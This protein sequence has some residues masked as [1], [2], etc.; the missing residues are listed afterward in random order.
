MDFWGTVVV[1]FRRWYIT[2]PAFF[3]TLVAA[4]A[5]LTAVPLQYESG[6]VLALTTPLSG[7]T[8]TDNP[9]APTSLTNPLLGFDQSLALTAS[10]VIQQLNSSETAR[11]LGIS[12][13]DTTGYEVNNGTT[14]P[15]LLQSGPLIFVRGTGSSPQAAQDIAERV[16]TLAATVLDERQDALGAPESTH[17]VVQVVVEPTAGQPLADSPLRAA[18]AVGA[19]A[20]MASLIAVYGFESLMVNRRRRR[21]ERLE[22]EGRFA[23][24]VGG[25]ARNGV[26]G[27]T[28]AGLEAVGVLSRRSTESS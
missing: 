24:L 16:S 5:A 3:L 12:A 8:E 11:S 15:E 23:A 13:G 18:A 9:D 27:G 2:V 25:S 21:R 1:L 19:L 28:G 22:R 26:R 4:G 7:G 17:I 20:G 6:S 10:I 14:N